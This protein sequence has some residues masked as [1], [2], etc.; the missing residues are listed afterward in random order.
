MCRGPAESSWVCCGEHRLPLQC[1]SETALWYWGTGYLCFSDLCAWG[2]F[3]IFKLRLK[4][5]WKFLSGFL[6]TNWCLIY[7]YFIYV[8][9]F[10]YIPV[11]INKGHLVE[12]RAESGFQK[13]CI[14]CRFG[15]ATVTLNLVKTKCH[16]FVFS[17]PY[18]ERKGSLVSHAKKG[19]QKSHGFYLGKHLKFYIFTDSLIF[20]MLCV[21]LVYHYTIGERELVLTC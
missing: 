11:I 18:M 14:S 12:N 19:Q 7:I 4:P 13:G 10:V 17:Q 5:T 15:K 8:T 9:R 21:R 20:S 2:G 6:C 16:Q 3:N 1:T